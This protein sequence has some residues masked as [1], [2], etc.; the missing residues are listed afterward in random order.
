MVVSRCWVRFET[1]Y[2][3][4]FCD[5]EI[6]RPKVKMMGTINYQSVV[7]DYLDHSLHGTKLHTTN[8]PSLALSLSLSLS[9]SFMLHRFVST[10]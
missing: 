5:R 8:A 3:V 2:A 4:V 10:S 1:R 6:A 7:L 9:L